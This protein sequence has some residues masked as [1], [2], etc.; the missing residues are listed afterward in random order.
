MSE[1]QRLN[2]VKWHHVKNFKYT[3]GEDLEC[4]L[5]V[6]NEYCSHAIMVLVKEKNSKSK[7]KTSTKLDKEWITVDHIPEDLTEILFPLV[8]SP[9]L[10]LFYFLRQ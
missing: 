3:I 2:H 10:F 1:L 8:R 9:C 5:E 7:R 4:K 6:Q